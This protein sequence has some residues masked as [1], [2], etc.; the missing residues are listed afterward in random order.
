MKF[1]SFFIITAITLAAF[2]NSVAVGIITMTTKSE[3]IGFQLKGSGTAIVDWGDDAKKDTLN[4][5]SITDKDGWMQLRCTDLNTFS[6]TIT[7]TGKNITGFDCETRLIVLDTHRK[8]SSCNQFNSLDVSQNPTLTYLNCSNNLLT[9]LDVSRNIALEYL[10]CGDNSLTKLD[11]SKN[12][13]LTNLNC[14]R[15]QLTELEISRNT[16]L[17]HLICGNNPLNTM[18]VSQN[19]ALKELRCD[20]NQLTALDVSQNIAM[21]VLSCNNNKITSLDISQNKALRDFS[22]MNNQLS[23]V[24]LNLIFGMLPNNI[25]SIKDEKMIF[26]SKNPGTAYCD[27]SIAEGKGWSV[28]LE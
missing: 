16:A 9:E 5:D 1:F 13:A 27:P 7:I 8:A 24:S 15:N 25:V 28:F 3:F 19:T 20:H 10:G 22:C 26:I 6:R 21:M 23:S 17:E 11:L 12:M 14:R 18:D 2:G 4:L